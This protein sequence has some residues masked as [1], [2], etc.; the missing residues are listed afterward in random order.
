MPRKEISL[1]SLK[2][3]NE[4]LE[5]LADEEALQRISSQNAL[6]VE[7]IRRDD[8]ALSDVRRRLSLALSVVETLVPPRC[9]TQAA[10]SVPANDVHAPLSERQQEI[11]LWVAKG[12]SNSVIA[13]ILGI[14]QHTVDTHLRRVYERLGASDRTVAAIKAVQRGLIPYA[15]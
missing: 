1:Q 4:I 15:A 2:D 13:S 12:K 7:E 5:G 8:A 10:P 6:V 14:S 11:M 3:L 9:D